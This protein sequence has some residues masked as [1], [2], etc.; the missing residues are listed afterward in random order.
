MKKKVLL[1]FI[2]L[3]IVNLLIYFGLPKLKELKNDKPSLGKNKD[4]APDLTLTGQRP[5]RVNISV[6]SA[7][8]NMLSGQLYE[9]CANS[10]NCADT[11]ERQG[12]QMFGLYYHSSEFIGS[13]CYCNCLEENKIKKALTQEQP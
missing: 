6:E 8:R 13:D 7:C 2:I 11:C 5:V 9:R 10:T 4:K 12:C 3:I 1:L